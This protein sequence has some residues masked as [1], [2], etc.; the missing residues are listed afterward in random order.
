M[1]LAAKLPLPPGGEVETGKGPVD[2]FPTERA[3]KNRL[4]PGGNKG[5]RGIIIYPAKHPPHPVLL[6][7]GEGTH[8]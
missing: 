8:D 1:S 5:V 7:Q 3:Q 6:P 2:L 4:R